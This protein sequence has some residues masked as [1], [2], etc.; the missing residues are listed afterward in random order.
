MDL[1]GLRGFT[2]D[3]WLI[4]SVDDPWFLIFSFWLLGA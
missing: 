3:P 4:G 1:E 2:L